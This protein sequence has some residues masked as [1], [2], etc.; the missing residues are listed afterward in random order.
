M[1]QIVPSITSLPVDS[2]AAPS[3]ED[4]QDR[5]PSICVDYL[6]HDWSEEDVW[7]SWRNMTRHKHEIANGVRLENASWRTWQKQRNNLKT[8]NPE[9][10]NWL[11]D[12]DVT[13]LYGPL[14]TASVEPVRAPKVASTDERLGIDRPNPAAKKKTTK[15]ILKHRTISEMLA[16]SMPSSPVLESAVGEPVPATIASVSDRPKLPQTKSDTNVLQSQGVMPR[17]KSPP[18]HPNLREEL[19]IDSPISPTES[20]QNA[21]KKHISFNTFVEQ[22]VAIEDPSQVPPQENKGPEVLE[23]KPAH[24]RRE[25][26]GSRPSLSRQSSSTSSAE[27]LTISMLAPTTLKP[28]PGT[29]PDLQMVYVPPVEYQSPDRDDQR[30]AYDFPS[31]EVDPRTGL[32]ESER[33]YGQGDYLSPGS[34]ATKERKGVPIPGRD[35]S[36]MQSKRQPS[37]PQQGKAEPF[38]YSPSSS[39]SSFNVSSSPQPGRGILKT[40]TPSHEIPES[41]SPPL[42]EFDYN[43][44]AATGIGGMRGSGSSYDYASGS[45]SPLMAPEIVGGE[46]GRAQSREH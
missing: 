23:M 6:S 13:W 7:A 12:S 16:T 18:R 5:L 28:G 32:E 19:P 27:R 4:L 14:H 1:A 2:S 21:N 9:T 25:S 46:R 3:V 44:S 30:D 11:K 26:H 29:N 42:A 36:P 31:P 39:T 41:E 33:E 35:G 38:S 40:R 22:C 24:E 20:Q 37:S 17:N 10:L 15:P 43:P 34:P 45:A 8:I